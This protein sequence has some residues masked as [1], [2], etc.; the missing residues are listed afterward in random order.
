MKKLI[1]FT[2]LVLGLSIGCKKAEITE[3]R[4]DPVDFLSSK[5]YTKVVVEMVY[6]KGYAPSDDMIRNTHAFLSTRLNKPGGIE[7][8]LREIVGPGKDYMSVFDIEGIEKEFRTKFSNRNTIAVFAYFTRGYYNGDA[9][10]SKTLGIAYDNTSIAIFER[11]IREYSGAV[12]QPNRGVLESTVMD[13]EFG[14]LFGLVDNGT[15]MINYH[16][17]VNNG[18]HCNNENCLM[19]Y[20]AETSDIV[21]NLLGGNIPSLDDNC[22]RDLQYNGGK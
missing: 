12:G 2:A 14:H 20:R 9:G 10:G 6:D 19:H 5:K 7:I 8:M 17:D 4:I 18:Y 22:I 11:T 15:P 3:A 1:L 21:G 16:R 13:H